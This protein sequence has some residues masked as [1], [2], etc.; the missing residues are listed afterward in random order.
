ML[1]YA[2]ALLALSAGWWAPV[3]QA[4]AAVPQLTICSHAFTDENDGWR[5]H[6]WQ[7]QDCTSGLPQPGWYAIG[8]A[9]NP[10]L[11]TGGQAECSWGDVRFAGHYNNPYHVGKTPG[12]LTCIYVSPAHPDVTVC[13][14]SFGV[15]V[16][17]WQ[18]TRTWQATD[19]SNGVPDLSWVAI[20]QPANAP[21]FEAMAECMLGASAR[22]GSIYNHPVHVGATT[23]VLRCMYVR[24][25]ASDLTICTHHWSTFEAGWRPS[26]TF[27]A[28]ECSGG[29]P[30]ATAAGMGEARTGRGIAAL[31]SCAHGAPGTV[32]QY[33]HPY[34][35][36]ATNSLLTCA[37]KS[38]RCGDGICERG[39]S[40]SACSQDCAAP[41]T[42]Q[43]V[44]RYVHTLAAPVSLSCTADAAKDVFNVVIP[45][46]G[47][48]LARVVS[49]VQSGPGGLIHF[50]N[51]AILVGQPELGFGIG[52]DVCPG[53]R[54]TGKANMGS[55]VLTTAQNR[56]QVRAYQGSTT[57][58]DGQLSIPAGARLDVWVEDPAPACRGRDITVDS[59]Y[60]ESGFPE[61]QV[62][63][64]WSTSMKTVHQREIVVA[65]A[66][67]TVELLSVVEGTPPANPNTTCGTEAGTLAVE[68]L[69]D[70]AITDQRI[71]AIP[72][73][74]GMGHLVMSTSS[75]HTLAPGTHDVQMRL[76]KNVGAAV[77]TG[78]C[79]GDAML[80]IVRRAP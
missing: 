38:A 11:G 78:G 10:V 51:F 28:Q 65:G 59:Y 75:R 80:G 8:E 71:Q 19:C 14:A 66:A 5:I 3:P 72:A 47:Y 42:C 62:P 43:P 4:Q 46:Q 34:H 27:L 55:G 60:V 7:P 52:D 24:P 49:D 54:A 6:K 1:R 18:A 68:T 73:S 74:G 30:L 77:Q 37:Y 32:S 45:D 61:H 36:D 44:R 79:C 21:G 12:A 25:G 15:A 9:R 57:C 17:G 35:A 22:G 2:V 31:S 64:Y 63:Y 69:L 26:H 50:W 48:A 67:E 41:P 53:T 76:G 23:G 20:G 16:G 13:S 39:E 58:I 29:L 40:A 33:N 70:G 56:V